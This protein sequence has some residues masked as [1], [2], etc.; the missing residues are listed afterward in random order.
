VSA[1]P[2]CER[3]GVEQT[4]HGG[5]HATVEGG[6]N[7]VHGL[8]GSIRRRG[9]SLAGGIDHRSLIQSIPK[10]LRALSLVLEAR[11]ANYAL[12]KPP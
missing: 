2:S 5:R 8:S 11:S 12:A 6:N 1:K 9:H 3:E 10:A 4:V 7:N